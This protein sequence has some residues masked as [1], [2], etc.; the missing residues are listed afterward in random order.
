LNISHLI[1]SLVRR[2]FVFGG[3]GSLIYSSFLLR[4]VGSLPNTGLK[5]WSHVAVSSHAG[6]PGTAAQVGVVDLAR[7][8]GLHDTRSEYWNCF[9]ALLCDL[10]EKQ[11]AQLELL[12]WVSCVN[13]FPKP[14]P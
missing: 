11:L 10:A 7:S 8:K 9:F 1:V 14:K 2:A 6:S 13:T 12:S 4:K 5:E 3:R